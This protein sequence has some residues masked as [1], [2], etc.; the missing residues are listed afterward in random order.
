MKVGSSAGNRL[1]KQVTCPVRIFERWPDYRA[2]PQ[3]GPAG[4]DD[5]L[6]VWENILG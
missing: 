1:L 5:G 4:F 3:T 2:T 6:D